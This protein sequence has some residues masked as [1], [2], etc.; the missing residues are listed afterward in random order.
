[1]EIMDG[2]QP[3]ERLLIRVDE[4]ARM[5]SMGRAK[6]YAMAASGELPGVVRIGKSVRISAAVLRAWIERQSNGVAA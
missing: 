6:T 5:L 2:R 3:P 1:M 4:A